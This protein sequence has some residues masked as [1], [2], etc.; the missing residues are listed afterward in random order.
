MRTLLIA[1]ALFVATALQAQTPLAQGDVVVQVYS[2]PCCRISYLIFDE[3]GVKKPGYPVIPASGSEIA[4]DDFAQLRLK[5]WT[6][7]EA[8]RLR[9]GE[10]LVAEHETFFPRLMKFDA[11]GHVV[12]VHDLPYE[13]YVYGAWH[14]EAF[15]DQ[16]TVAWTSISTPDAGMYSNPLRPLAIRAFDICRNE[17]LPDLLQLPAGSKRPE[18][19]RQ[20][21]NGDW[22]VVTSIEVVQ[23]QSSGKVVA[24]WPMF[25]NGVAL[26]HDGRG[27]W[28]IEHNGFGGA[29]RLV[30]IDF[31][32]PRVRR[33]DQP[34]DNDSTL[35]LVAG[36]WYSAVQPAPLQPPSRRRSVRR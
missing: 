22:L 36:D 25:T 9:S 7:T 20:L 14:L 28:A 18:D 30:R 19:L 3:N 21:A 6:V 13:P 11:A 16:C 15:A 35:E 2:K 32:Q 8:A 34:V 29:S 27:F 33:V 10:F 31:D 23:F 5:T 12:S 26:T 17:A 1:I 24:S 4:P